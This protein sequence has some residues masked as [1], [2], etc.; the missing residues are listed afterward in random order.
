M[1]ASTPAVTLIFGRTLLSSCPDRIQGIV[2][3]HWDVIGTVVCSVSKNYNHGGTAS[4]ALILKCVW[5]EDRINRNVHTDN[6]Q[7]DS[8]RAKPL[9]IL[10]WFRSWCVLLK[11]LSEVLTNLEHMSVEVLCFDFREHPFLISNIRSLFSAVHLSRISR[12]Q[13][14]SLDLNTDSIL[15]WKVNLKS[16]S[17]LPL[18]LLRWRRSFRRLQCLL[19]NLQSETFVFY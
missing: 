6:F 19:F 3:E 4:K 15:V 12:Q 8:K 11:Q 10:L 17:L 13:R 16:V 9:K 7:I 5:Q 1:G 14:G 18:I 2:W